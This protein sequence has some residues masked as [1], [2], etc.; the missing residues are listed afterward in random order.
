MPMATKLGTMV[1]RLEGL[2]LKLLDPL[3]TWSCDITWQTRNVSP[4]PQ[5]LWPQNLARWWFT[6]RVFY[7]LSHMTILSRRLARWGDKLKSLYIHYH[8]AYGYQTWQGEESQK[9]LWSRG[10]TRSCEKLD[11]IYLYYHKALWPQKLAR[12]WLFIR[13]FRL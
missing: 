4:L 5:W 3:I 2:L 8:N 9:A 13:S 6:M 12:R 7:P 11:L 1:I 10:F